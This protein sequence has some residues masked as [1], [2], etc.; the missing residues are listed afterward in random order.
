MIRLALDLEMN[1]GDKQS[2]IQVGACIFNTETSE[3]L[4]TFDQIVFQNECI[5]PFIIKLTG[6]TQKKVNEGRPLIN[7]YRDLVDFSTRHNCRV[8]PI[9]TWGSGDLKLLKRQVA[10]Y[11]SWKLGRT[12]MDVKSIYQAYCDANN[13]DLQGGLKGATNKMGLIFD[14]PAHNALKDSVATAKLYCRLLD[15]LRI[16][17][18][19]VGKID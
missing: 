10:E 12:E 6:I 4:D 13:L 2:I 19:L 3:I 15:I 18:C 9:V 16:K 8:F 5:T 7:V 1:E 14:G 11:H 17:E